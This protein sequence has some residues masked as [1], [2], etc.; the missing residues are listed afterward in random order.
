M[1]IATLIPHADFGDPSCCGCLTGELQDDI[2]VISCEECGAVV[3][4]V[5]ASDFQRTIE[6]M[7]VSLDLAVERC[8]NLAR[9]I[10]CLG[11]NESSL[12]SAIP[13]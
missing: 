4:R 10:S 9:L 11:L 1:T 12:S 13:A 5:A 6:Q 7:E 8:S 2:A 3:R